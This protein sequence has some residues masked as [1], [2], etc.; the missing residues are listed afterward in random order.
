MPISLLLLRYI[1]AERYG[2]YFVTRGERD[3]RRFYADATF[4]II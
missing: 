2:C 4:N 1:F 3:T